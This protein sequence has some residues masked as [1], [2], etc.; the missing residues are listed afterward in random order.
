MGYLQSEAN[1]NTT[2]WHS[3]KPVEPHDPRRTGSWCAFSFIQ[4]GDWRHHVTPGRLGFGGYNQA[5]SRAM[6][7]TLSDYYCNK[8]RTTI[9]HRSHSLSEPPK[10]KEN[11]AHRPASSSHRPAKPCIART[12]T[13]STSAMTTAELPTTRG[14]NESRREIW[15]VLHVCVE[16]GMDGH[17]CVHIYFRSRCN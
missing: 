7:R 13:A 4:V 11:R 10:K 9:E 12:G 6:P 2:R 15:A 5:K 16:P 14:K 8:L 3:K 17:R 1:L